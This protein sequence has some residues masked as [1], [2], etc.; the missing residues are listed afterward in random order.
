MIAWLNG[1]ALVMWTVY[2][3]PKDYPGAYVARKVVIK[4]DIYGP[5]NES[6]S[7]RSLRDVRN[8]LQ[9]LYPG[10]IQL[11]RSPTTNRISWRY[12]Y[13]ARLARS[14][15]AATYGRGANDWSVNGETLGICM[16]MNPRPI[17][18]WQALQ[19]AVRSP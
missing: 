7:S 9:S 11:K 2:K 17:P 14:R 10:L 19:A 18:T 1:D 15:F 3:H 4:E 5:S 6:I 8:V 12:G 16:T 13:D